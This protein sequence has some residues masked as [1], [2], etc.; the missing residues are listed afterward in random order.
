MQKLGTLVEKC[1]VVLVAFNDEMLPA[2]KLKAASEIFSDP[3][4]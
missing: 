2:A 3:P 1:R 4:D